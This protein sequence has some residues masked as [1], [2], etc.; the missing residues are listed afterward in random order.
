MLR[1]GLQ[2]LT[3][4][5]GNLLRRNTRSAGYRRGNRSHRSWLFDRG[6]T[7][8]R[9]GDGRSG[10]GRRIGFN[11]YGGLI[12]G[13]HIVPG[14]HAFAFL[15]MLFGSFHCRE[16]RTANHRSGPPPFPGSGNFHQSA[17]PILSGRRCLCRRRSSCR[18]F[19]SGDPTRSW[20]HQRSGG[21]RPSRCS[22]RFR[23]WPPS[24][25][26]RHQCA[27]CWCQAR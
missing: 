15:V 4:M 1:S 3:W 9:F 23:Y 19:P 26:G 20:S 24:S 16:E 18:P 2:R 17:L 7:W 25:S 5:C 6:R 10:C 13:R 11:C 14:F 21:L 8:G 22:N 27:R 12:T